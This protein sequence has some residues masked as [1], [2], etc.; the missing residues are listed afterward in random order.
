MIRYPEK[1]GIAAMFLATI[2][3]AATFDRLVRDESFRSTATRVA[4][5]VFALSIAMLGLTTIPSWPSMFESIFPGT[6]S[7]SAL[8]AACRAS[9]AGLALRAGVV[10]AVTML[11]SL[12]RRKLA[13]VSAIA[14]TAADLSLQSFELCPRMPRSFLD[15]P[16]LVSMTSPDRDAWRLFHVA[17]WNTSSPVARRHLSDPAT[18]IWVVRNGLF[19]RLP[20]NWGI[21]SAFDTDIDQTQLLPTVDLA[22]AMRQLHDRSPR[23]IELLSSMSNVRYVALFSADPSRAPGPGIAPSRLRPIDLVDLGENPRYYVANTVGVARNVAEFVDKVARLESAKGVAFVESD[24]FVPARGTIESVEERANGARVTLSAEGNTLLV[25]AVTAHK[26]WSATVDG[27]PAPIRRVNLAYQGIVVPAGA[28]VV[29][30]RYR[31]PLVAAGFAV[32]AIALLGAVL[33]MRRR[34]VIPA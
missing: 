8:A 2:A 20:A 19:P 30:W 28:H 5:G 17:E 22:E 12:G 29:E 26:Y 34:R 24:P 21:R 10:C 25:A 32:S 14:L 31:N 7:S 16:E 27:A 33:A 9:A 23:F 3:A 15:A 4:A 18:R 13:L 1:L 11:F 6:G